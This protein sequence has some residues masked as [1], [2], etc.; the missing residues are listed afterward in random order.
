VWDNRYNNRSWGCA[1]ANPCGIAF[2]YT[3]SL[4]FPAPGGFTFANTHTCDSPE[5]HCD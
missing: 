5:Q 2:T 4:T 1:G 3:G